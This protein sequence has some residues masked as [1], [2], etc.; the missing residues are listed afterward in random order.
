MVD[1]DN[2]G[3]MAAVHGRAGGRQAVS[4]ERTASC[5]LD[6]SGHNGIVQAGASI[7]TCPAAAVCILRAAGR[8]SE[9]QPRNHDKKR[10]SAGHDVSKSPAAGWP[11]AK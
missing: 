1:K 11:R 3:F 9:T 2:P 5:R 6:H 8:W 4:G 10:Q 7:L